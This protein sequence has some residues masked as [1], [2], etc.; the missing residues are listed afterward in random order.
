MITHK[1][2]ING[3]W[4]KGSVEMDS[5]NPENDKVI[6]K[7]YNATNTEV[8]LAI[9]SANKS[10]ISWK[11]TN[12]K[13]R[14]KYL[15][16]VA[17]ILVERYGDE[18]VVTDL[19]KLIV[20]E[21]GKRLP[22]A[23]IEVIESAD[24]V[25]YFAKEGIELLQKEELSLNEELW[26]TKKSYI[27]HNPIGVVGIIQ[28]WNYPL[29][30]PI[31]SISA[32]LIAGNTIVFKPSEHSSIIG[33]EIGKIFQEAGLPS[34]VLNII[35]G[36]SE[37]GKDLVDST[38]VNM[39]SFTGSLEIGKQINIKCA[40]TFKK[41]NLELSGND[42]AIVLNDA[43]LE[44]ATNGIIWG[45][46]CNGGQVCVGAKRIFVHKNI[47]VQFVKL[48]VEKTKKLKLGV[49]IGPIISK[50]QLQIIQNQISDALDKGAKILTGGDIKE[51]YFVPT[52]ITNLNNSMNLMVKE[53]FGPI[54]P[55]TPFDD[56]KDAI[57]MTNNSQYGLGASI[58]TTN[59][60]KGQEIAKELEVGMV[61][62]ND[63][64]VAFPEAPWQGIKNSGRGV[65][66]SKFGI[67]EY[68]QIKHINYETSNEQSR[69]WWF[70][71]S[72][73]KI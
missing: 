54:L 68:T 61:W 21:V 5:I 66:L 71:Y 35:T 51:N 16:S 18:G 60:E 39:I 22:E 1:L 6:A 43:D 14:A 29:E 64:N 50:K 41:V 38:N 31:W 45:A 25:S 34:G 15:E 20:D 69:L 72:E 27:L 52:V 9:A 19:K 17:N 62:V 40:E 32:A 11:N 13:E 7:V 42:A 57:A 48:I 30:L 4:V 37:T 56:D 12:V 3:E 36:D 70:P 24:M 46:Y 26:V 73:T 65:S 28:P 67:L 23:D 49:D 44:L 8:N 2:L 47:Y 33:L 63:V 10:L 59:L 58:W 53:L 55:I